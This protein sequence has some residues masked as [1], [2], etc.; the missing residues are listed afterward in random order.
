M[1]F[2]NSTPRARIAALAITLAGVLGAASIGSGP[3][4]DDT[5]AL[6]PAHEARAHATAI[7]HQTPHAEPSTAPSTTRP[8]KWRRIPRPDG[9]GWTVCPPRAKKC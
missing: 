5:I 4:P 8:P 3:D 9:N 1:S 7:K 2:R 6:R